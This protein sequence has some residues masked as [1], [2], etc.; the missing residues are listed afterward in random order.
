[1]AHSNSARKRVRQNVTSAARNKPLRTR[2]AHTVRDAREAIAAGDADAAERL[3]AAQVALD[4]AARHHIIHPNAAAR[5]KS[6]LARALKQA[7]TG[8]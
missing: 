2:A 8:S 3:R 1:M 5:R 4:R 6:R 7:A